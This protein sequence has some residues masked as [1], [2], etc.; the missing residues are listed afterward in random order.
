MN[1]QIDEKENYDDNSDY[2]DDED[3]GPRSASA[4]V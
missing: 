4:P 1:D 2:H 3:G